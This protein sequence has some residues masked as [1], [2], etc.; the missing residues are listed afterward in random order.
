MWA[1]LREKEGRLFVI[2]I[3][4][5]QATFEGWMEVMEDAIDATKVGNIY[6]CFVFFW[7]WFSTNTYIPEQHDL[8]VKSHTIL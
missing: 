6:L 5:F 1:V 2:I 7:S 3:I 8:E 4:A